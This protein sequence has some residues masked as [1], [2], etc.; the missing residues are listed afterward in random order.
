MSWENFFIQTRPYTVD[1]FH[2]PVN[3]IGSIYFSTRSITNIYMVPKL[4]L[5]LF[6]AGQL[7][8]I[9]FTLN[10]SNN[11]VDV[12]DSQKNQLIRIDCKIGRVFEVP[13]FADSLTMYLQLLLLSLIPPI[14]GILI[15]WV[16]P[17]FLVFNF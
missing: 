1:D 13:F 15:N 14:Y 12:Q 8:Q 10:F 7:C 16:V 5:N 3:H 2:L 6:Y 17:L 9:G 4:S 11:G